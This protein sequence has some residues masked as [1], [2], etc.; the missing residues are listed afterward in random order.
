MKNVFFI[1]ITF[2]Y[3]SLNAIAENTAIKSGKY[4]TKT[5]E[6]IV[7]FNLLKRLEKK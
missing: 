4:L 5:L 7:P 1:T 3:L 2:F 6:N